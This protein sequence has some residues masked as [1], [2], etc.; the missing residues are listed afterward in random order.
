M[1]Q[2]EEEKYVGDFIAAFQYLS[3]SIRA[4]QKTGE[5]RLVIIQEMIF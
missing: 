3:V 1:V 5:G 4:Y 2:S